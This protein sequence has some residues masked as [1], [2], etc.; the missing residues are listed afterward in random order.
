MHSKDSLAAQDYQAMVRVIDHARSLTLKRL[1]K[2]DNSVADRAYQYLRAKLARGEMPPGTRLVTRH[3]AE[4]VNGSLS[5]VREAITR[6]VSE[7]LVAHFPGGGAYVKQPSQEEVQELYDVRAQLEEMAVRLAVP[8]LTESHLRGLT[9]ACED[10]QGIAD[11]IH[12]RPG[13][14]ADRQLM[15]DFLDD[16]ARFHSII[17]RASGNRFLSK[18]IFDLH[19]ISRVFAVIGRTPEYLTSENATSTCKGHARLL[20]LVQAGDANGA[21]DR[22]RQHIISGRNTVIAFL[23]EHERQQPY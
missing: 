11:L 4:A 18:M 10:M 20:E 5:P 2:M 23:D 21:A 22:V 17:V 15:A 19:I 16:D 8:R 12:E 14:H 7:G 3:I 6:L 1:N 13:Q 9:A